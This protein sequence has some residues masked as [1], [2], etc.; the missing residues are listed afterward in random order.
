MIKGVPFQTR[1]R[2]IDHLGREQIADCPTAITELWKNA[3]D[4]YAREVSLHLFDGEIPV[5]G[6]YDD[7]HGMNIDEFLEKWLVI[8]TDSKTSNR[9][10]NEADR[11]GL[12]IRPKL[13]QKGIGRLSC[14]AMGSLLLLVSKR[15][16]SDYIASLIDWRIFENPFLMLGD[17]S[18]PVS[19]FENKEDILQSLPD[20]Q[21]HLLDNVWPK[22]IDSE[23]G[24]RVEKAWELFS[25]L[26]KDNGEEKSTSEKISELIVEVA[27]LER[28]IE[29][30][31]LWRAQAKKGT[32]LIMANLANSLLVNLKNNN[33]ISDVEAEIKDGYFETLSAFYDPYTLQN[34]LSI[35]YKFEIWTGSESRVALSN[36]RQFDRESLL[37]LEHT[38]DGTFEENG[39]FKGHIKVF[40]EELGYVEIPPPVSY[41]P[42]QRASKIGPLDICLGTYEGD[43]GSSTLTAD[44]HTK[45]TEDARKFGGFLLYR[46]NLRL[47]PY[48]RADND[49]FEIEERR[50]KNAGDEFWAARRLF[51]RIAI[52]RE[53]NP[54][55]R[56]KA[57]REGLIDNAA[58]RALKS[59]IINFL[60]HLAH[61]YFGKRS[62][63]RKEKLPLIQAANEKKASEAAKASSLNIRSNFRNA[64]R[65]NRADLD[66]ELEQ[67]DSLEKE[68]GGALADRNAEALL[69]ILDKIDT[70]RANKG[71]LRLPPRPK[72]LGTLEETFVKYSKDYSEWNQRIDELANSVSCSLE[73]LNPKSPEE[74]AHSSLRRQAKVVHDQIRNWKNEISGIL[75]NEVQ[76]FEK[77]VAE[78]LK[79][80]DIQ[81]TPLL[82]NLGNKT[83]G[84]SSTLRELDEL[85][86]QIIL[87]LSEKYTP[88]IRAITS[89][90]KG[91]DLDSASYWNSIE[92]DRLTQELEK[93]SGLAQ[94]GITVELISHELE[95]LDHTIGQHLKNLPRE[96]QEKEDFKIAKHA[97]Q[98]LTDRLRF[99]SPLQLSGASKF[100]TTISGKMICDY[101]S[102]FFKKAFAE[103]NLVFACTETFMGLEINEFESRIYPVFI[104]LVNNAR[105]WACQTNAPHEIRIDFKDGKVIIGDT[106][107]GVSELDQEQLFTLYFTKKMRGRGVG[108]YLC[109]TNLAHGRHDIRYATDS[110]E[111]ILSGA[112][113]VIE[114]NGVKNG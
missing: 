89:L 16:R 95:R 13:G 3:Y 100:R 36:T 45:V 49:F 8:G 46:D 79:L 112:N 93:F 69:V 6:I 63:I 91:L 24:K 114:F 90:S 50:G 113:F 28:H 17:I 22:N 107:P 44:Q 67:I 76:R 58:R 92:A 4:A 86:D 102:A 18:I 81:A 83:Q 42:A 7:G 96:I 12:E 10:I 111:K 5:A 68:G 23:R 53:S 32:A 84:L 108:L 11:D 72:K 59:L 29:N 64:L 60:R 97:H 2:T 74:I 41:N 77:E 98:E 109:R 105:Y 33:T 75:S 21:E 25:A 31:P 34:S 110:S 35:D 99:L 104:N 20:M 65:D 71:Q 26:E 80:Y 48:G 52:T 30:W 14:G 55:L 57:G 87:L 56:D 1:A 47:L 70:R 101:I 37:S 78:D 88:Y 94:M 40:N 82:T 61:N 38:V 27:F 51:G 66:K 103:S 9:A 106:G 19:E 54:N 15:T 73:E 39:V 43:A 85:R 62:S